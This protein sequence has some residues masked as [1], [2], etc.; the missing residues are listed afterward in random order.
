MKN[1]ILKRLG[2]SACVLSMVLSSSVMANTSN[3]ENYNV[4]NSNEIVISPRTSTEPIYRNVTDPRGTISTYWDQTQNYSYYRVWYDN[5][6][7]EEVTVTVQGSTATFPHVVPANSGSG[8]V[9]NNASFDR[10]FITV[11]SKYGAPL[12][13]WLGV[14]IS[15]LPLSL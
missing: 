5:N 2:I 14:R 8:F 9:V 6:S 12:N 4:I 1:K 10:H 11:E 3:Q 15:D 7:N 13:G